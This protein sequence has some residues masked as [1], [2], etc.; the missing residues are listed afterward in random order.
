MSALDALLGRI[1]SN[2]VAIELSGG[3]NFKT[4]FSATLDTETGLVNIEADANAIHSRVYRNVLYVDPASAAGGSGSQGAPFTSIQAAI[5]SVS[6]PLAE[7]TLIVLPPGVSITENLTIPNGYWALTSPAYEAVYLNGN[8]DWDADGGYLEITNVVLTGDITVAAAG[9]SALALFDSALFGDISQTGAGTCSLNCAGKLS[10]WPP[11]FNKLQGTIQVLGEIHL[12]NFKVQGALTCT[13]NLYANNCAL[14]NTSTYTVGGTSAQF[15]DC[16]VFAT[17]SVVFSGSAG[18]V[19]LDPFTASQG[20]IGVSNGRIA[21]TLGSFQ[22]NDSYSNNV[23]A[24]YFTNTA[25]PAGLYRVSAENIVTAGTAGASVLNVIYVGRNG[26]ATKALTSA[27]NSGDASG[28]RTFWHDG[29]TRIQYS[30]T[31]VTP[32][33]LT[34]FVTI[35]LE[36]L[37]AQAQT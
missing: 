24:T 20:N 8:V 26:S 21:P 29:S 10:N 25:N 17:I 7:Q 14:V 5:D 30:V 36:Y 35:Q 28:D 15:A 18:A 32:S 2:D 27:I 16:G 22:I 19:V 3:L 6:A 33:G 13:G 34:A 1:L 11:T 23:S 12:E 9:E 37:G 4:P 31:G